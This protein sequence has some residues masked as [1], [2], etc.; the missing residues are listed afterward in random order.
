MYFTD[1]IYS[2]IGYWNHS[3][4]SMVT[5]CNYIQG[6]YI[7]AQSCKSHHCNVECWLDDN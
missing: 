6:T 4:L 3:V 2:S 1:W 5:V 7:A